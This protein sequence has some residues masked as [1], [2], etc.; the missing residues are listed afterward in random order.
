[1]EPSAVWQETED[2]H[3]YKPVDVELAWICVNCHMARSLMHLVSSHYCRM[4]RVVYGVIKYQHY[5]TGTQH[6]LESKD[7]I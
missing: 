2:W 6:C 1:M 3:C 5:N 7:G 4:I